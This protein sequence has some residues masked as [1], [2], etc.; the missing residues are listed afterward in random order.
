LARLDDPSKH[1]KFNPGDLDDRALWSE[2]QA[3]YNDVLARCSTAEAA[4]H[5]VPADRKWYRNWAVANLLLAHLTDLDLRFPAGEFDVAA[6]RVRLEA[7]FNTN[8]Q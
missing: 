5:V 6:Q 2:Y 7:S 3:A 8:S 1:W 4:W